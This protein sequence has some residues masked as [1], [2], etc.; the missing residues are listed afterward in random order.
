MPGHETMPLVAMAALFFLISCAVGVL[1]PVKNALALDGL[2]G[3]GFYKVYLVSGAVLLFVPPYLRLANRVDWRKLVPGLALFFG[4]NLLLFR[5]I[6]RPGSMWQGLAFYGWY[7]LCSAALVSQFFIVAQYL[8][9]VRS[10]KRAYPLVIAGGS[11]G[12]AAGGA[13]TGFFAERI[14]TPNLLLIA[15]ALIVAFGML[16]PVSVTGARARPP[17]TAGT[18]RISLTGVRELA[19]DPHIRLIAVMVLVTI[20]V[21]QIVDYQFNALTKEAFITT[22]A[23]SAFQGKFN[24]ATQ[25]LPLFVLAALHPLLRRYG[26]GV[27]VLMLPAC[28]LMANVGLALFWT[29]WAGVFA[30]ATETTLRYSAERAG[31]EIL[32]VPV[33]DA[34]KLKAKT[35]IDV[36]LEEGLGKALSAGMIFGLLLILDYRQIAWVGILLSVV[37]LVLS[38]EVRRQYVRTLARSIEGRFASVRGLFGS[39]ADSTTWDVLRRG[40]AAEDPLRT[41]FALDLIAQSGVNDVRAL[42]PELQSLLDHPSAEIRIRALDLLERFPQV[43]PAAVLRPRLL[44]AS[45]AVREAAVRAWCAASGNGAAVEELL[46]SD[47][48]AV[49]TATL[50][51]IARGEL[52]GAGELAIRRCYRIEAWKDPVP[53]AERRAEL[54]MAAGALA[55]DAHA[56]RLVESLL[57]DPDPA[58]ASAALASAARLGMWRTYP[59]LIEALGAPSTREAARTA[60][61]LV[62]ED[63]V[64]VLTEHLLDERTDPLV[65]RAMPSVLARIPSEAA[66]R[67]LLHAVIAPETDP[68]LDFRTIKAL[69]RLRSRHP[70]LTFRPGPVL[71]VIRHEVSAARRYAAGFGAL[72]AA[73]PEDAITVVTRTA[74]ADAWRQR[75]ECAFR[76]LGL[77]NPA[78]E[79]YRCYLAVTG[80]TPTRANA[81]EWLEETVGYSLF[82]EIEPIL[83]P[84]P[85]AEMPARPPAEVLAALHDDADVWIAACAAAVSRSLGPAQAPSEPDGSHMDLIETV[86]LLQRVD[87]LKDA[88]SAHLALLAGIAEPIDVD[89]DAV[90]IREGDPNEA[91]Y[92]VTRGQVALEGVG[93]QIDVDDG[94]AFGTWAL[95]DE[96][97]SP[98]QA[99]ATEPT[100][101]LRIRRVDFLDLVADHP[102]LAIGLLQGLAR[103]IRT[104]VA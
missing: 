99:R 83:R 36:A 17:G 89:R 91:L 84:E 55:G 59:K 100:Q 8:V 86:F 46:S 47:A 10:A 37:W 7:D 30:K 62:G 33:P 87:L 88:R 32:Y 90:L 53:D 23:V 93:G 50:A 43:V 79:V 52:R 41:K 29:L 12:A 39:L 58:V 103:R 45:P 66:V 20:L 24:F 27:A 76:C 64:P 6:Y 69:S 42:A 40:L 61:T 38:L 16:L 15:A 35:Y 92:I 95:I 18:G 78:D 3:A 2:G 74:L 77:L 14:G 68:W 56:E 57:D 19:N 81:L 104:L 1:R 72:A 31:R 48:I 101:L 67:A 60:L 4:V 9:D 34:L 73:A 96:A 102:E 28:M 13:V 97:S 49:R 94:G 65:R 5:I 98:V 51:C 75:R 21:K 11:I 70:E 44:D 80:A 26:I 85:G 82:R 22:D 54:A 71:E 25:W 63:A